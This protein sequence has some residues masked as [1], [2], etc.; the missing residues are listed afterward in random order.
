MAYPYHSHTSLPLSDGPGMGL[1]PSGY[2]P[3]YG[4]TTVSGHGASASIDTPPSH[5]TSSLKDRRDSSSQ[6]DEELKRSVSSPNVR[7]HSSNASEHHQIGLPGEKKKNKLGYH[8]TSVACGHCRRRKIRCIPSASDEQG[9][10]VNCIR[11]KKECSFYPVDQAPPSDARPKAS[12]RASTAGSKVAS[13]SSSPAL[14]TQPYPGPV[15]TSNPQMNPQHALAV[16][17]PGPGIESPREAIVASNS[18][19]P[20][21]G[22]FD[23]AAQGLAGWVS[24]D[25]SPNSAP[26]P[27]GMGAPWIS[28]YTAQTP[29]A[30]AAWNGALHHADPGSTPG[31]DMASWSS[32]APGP[33]PPRSMPFGHEGHGSSPY[34]MVPQ[35]AHQVP[36]TIPPSAFATHISTS[37]PASTATSHVD[38]AAS[39][40]AGAIPHAGQFGAWPQQQHQPALGYTRPGDDYAQWSYG[41][42]DG[43]TGTPIR[44][45]HHPDAG[46]YPPSSVGMYFSER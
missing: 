36:A 8:R 38:H 37:L 12:S 45:E 26:K 21:P 29:Q 15:A 42:D 39:L 23:F 27:L 22:T 44:S 40:S 20:S 4:A 46:D 18:A 10:C 7:P 24:Q 1:A 14:S 11:L 9:R 34:G 19:H 32:Y 2:L 5:E 43:S 25:A 28:P 6:A 3:S 33:A 17:P 30:T 41:T 35:Q 13:S 16:E 31:E